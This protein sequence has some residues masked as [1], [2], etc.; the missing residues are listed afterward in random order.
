MLLVAAAAA[1]VHPDP[2]QGKFI[3]FIIQF[4]SFILFLE[5]FEISDVELIWVQFPCIEK[6]LQ[7]R[8]G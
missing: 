3:T 6:V 4:Y 5:F 2:D 8:N 7:V 1:V